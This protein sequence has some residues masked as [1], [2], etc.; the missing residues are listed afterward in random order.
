MIV[1]MSFASVPDP[2]LLCLQFVSCP[3][4]LGNRWCTIIMQVSSSPPPLFFFFGIHCCA[5]RGTEP[6]VALQFVYRWATG[7]MRAARKGV[8]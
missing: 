6:H 4:F 7:S 2:F 1:D 3:L 8:L 5:P